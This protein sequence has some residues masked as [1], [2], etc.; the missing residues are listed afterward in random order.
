MI[1]EFLFILIRLMICL[2]FLSLIRVGH[3][4]QALVKFYNQSQSL[5]ASHFPDQ[6]S[7]LLH[8]VVFVFLFERYDV[9]APFTVILTELI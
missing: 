9:K 5:Y 8:I 7:Q 2:K 1:I 4:G 3:L 6:T